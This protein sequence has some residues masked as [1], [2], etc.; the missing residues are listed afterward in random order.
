MD[1]V[2]SNY[3]IYCRES[4]EHRDT[5]ASIPAQ[6]AQC[7]ELATKLNLSV[8]G[9]IRE[10][11]SAR[12]YGRPKFSNLLAAI[13]GQEDLICTEAKLQKKVRPD[14]IIAWHPDRLA[15]NWRDAGEIIELLDNGQLSDMKF[16]MYSFHNDSSGKEHLAM[17]F[18]R[19]K[20]YSDHLQDNVMRG[21]IEK[22]VKGKGIRP[23]SP[24]FEVKSDPGGREHRKIIP[25][26][27][28]EQWRSV[29][30]WRLEGKNLKEIV[31]LLIDAG[32]TDRYKYGGRWR[33]IEIT[34]K[35][36]SRHLRNPL[37]CGWLVTTNSEEPRR[38]DLTTI[39]PQ[40]YGHPFPAVVT[41]EE[42]KQVNPELFSDS[43]S[44]HQC[45]RKAKYSL[46]G[47]VFCKAR[48]EA[49]LSPY[50]MFANTPR[51]GSGLPS[52]RFSCHRCK[53][54]R[55]V[56]MERIFKAVEVKLRGVRLTEREHKL[57]VVSAWEKYRKDRDRVQL[58]RQQIASLKTQNVQEIEEA[59]EILNTMEYGS[60]K[61]SA[62][63]I[64]AQKSRLQRLR[65]EQ[66]SLR[67]R[68]EKNEEE[69]LRRYFDLRA[70][71]ELAKSGS[72][73]WRKASPE[74]K[75]LMGDILIS[76][77]IVDMQGRPTVSLAEPFLEWSKGKKGKS[78]RGDR[79]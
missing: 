22:E 72:R 54:H 68:E 5:N 75:R 19:A 28:H 15:R 39:F 55:S 53:G 25:S 49:G 51:G 4:D 47:K 23:L 77:V 73:W 64:T 24:A 38:A 65:D 59:E 27:R 46:S 21:I 62:E 71:L 42:F 6:L 52:P 18:A 29:Y 34:D 50:T 12:D 69:G 79:T 2:A 63:R 45:R 48:Q 57:F 74:Q 9:V 67:Q 16:V 56:H 32:Y 10:K 7:R 30:R 44:Q 11:R 78:G 37:H 20:S 76:N 36:V 61:A 14:G 17:E 31:D 35:Y 60:R 3:V 43:A 33:E 13:K 40:E 70:F 8:I 1:S 58:A 66:K 41:L 26:E